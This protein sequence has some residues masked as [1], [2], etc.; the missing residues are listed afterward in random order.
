M[1][2]IHIFLGPGLSPGMLRRLVS[3]LQNLSTVDVNKSLLLAFTHE[4]IQGFLGNGVD[5]V[6]WEHH[7]L[8]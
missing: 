2:N 1:V 5:M 3:T 8:L 7:E 4:N 6:G